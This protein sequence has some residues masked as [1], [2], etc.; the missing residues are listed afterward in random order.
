MQRFSFRYLSVMGLVVLSLFLAACGA[1]QGQP[2][3]AS[4]TP[5]I[6]LPPTQVPTPTSTA[7]VENPG[8]P[9]GE[10]PTPETQ[11]DPRWVV[12]ED[13]YW[14]YSFAVP[15][16]WPIYS[17]GE[18]GVMASTSIASYDEAYFLANSVKGQWLGGAPPVGA[19]KMDLT[20]M[21]QIPAEAD[22]LRISKD[23]LSGGMPE[24]VNS[25]EEVLVG[26]KQAWRLVVR[27][28]FNPEETATVHVFR[29]APDRLF[30]VSIYP[31]AAV[32]SRDAQVILES[33]SFSPDQPVRIPA[34]SPSS[35]IIPMPQSCSQP[36]VINSQ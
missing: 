33:L 7:P 25:V 4:P 2:A 32:H 27:S 29:S 9:G 28:Q 16:W 26:D 19:V 34:G 3:P 6:S 15:C 20:T 21:L 31:E 5:E 12:Y 1:G 30:F 18:Q 14:G 8:E 36:R 13:W 11:M 10:Q 17:P 22:T 23:T 24:L 35:P